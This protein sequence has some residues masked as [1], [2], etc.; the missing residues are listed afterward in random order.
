M[1]IFVKK[2]LQTILLIILHK[3]ERNFWQ[4]KNPKL[5]ESKKDIK[6]NVKKHTKFD[7]SSPGLW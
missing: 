5:L 3:L 7:Q 2:K 1:T 4:K 6:Q